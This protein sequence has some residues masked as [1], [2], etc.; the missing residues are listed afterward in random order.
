MANNGFGFNFGFNNDDDDDENKNNSG[1]GNPFGAFSFG[2]NFNVPQ[3]GNL[4]DMLN[5]FGEML[6][7]LGTS[8]NSPEGA[9]PV[10]MD[11]AKR[12]AR[13]AIG[14]VSPVVSEQDEKAV[15]EAVR[16]VDLWL[17]GS[18]DIAT[19]SC[20]VVAWSPVNWLE[21]TLP[22][23]ER[24]YTPI[25]AAMAQ[26]QA[27]QLPEQLRGATEG[28]LPFLRQM[29]SASA[30]VELG[31]TIGEMALNTVSGSE[32][33]FPLAPTATT[34]LLPRAIKE[35]AEAMGVAPQEAMVYIAAR[36]VAHQRLYSHVPWLAERLVASVEEYAAGLDIDNSG[37]EEAMR[38]LNL[39]P[40]D[41]Q[42]IQEK[43]RGFNPEDLGAKFI[44]SNPQAVPRLETLLALVE[45]WVDYV[46]ADALG[47]RIPST[48]ALQEA[49]H[50]RRLEEGGKLFGGLLTITIDVS[51]ILDAR[52]LWRRVSDAVGPAKRDAIW[53]A[54]DFMPSAED[55]ENPAGFI[56]GLLDESGIYDF[57]PISE[58]EALEKLLAEDS[59]EDSTDHTE[60][61]SEDDSKDTSEE[62]DPKQQ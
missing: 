28:I 54:P 34:A 42:S 51:K 16:L 40:S 62:T 9:G 1:S 58:I 35:A 17:S 13:E 50:R 36:E 59:S 19:T 6:A 7:G 5:Q 3:G 39:D 46:V 24:L 41:P 21:A 26:A 32:S 56:D 20:Q 30:G 48:E 49:W 29:G 2:G 61:D 8:M 23:W 22:M 60:D 44:S 4:G 27:A 15:T 47:Q 55:L 37:L 12:F 11:M 57:D 45:G 53:D 14:S 25:A 10:N 43:L 18:T 33:G 52:E 38:N 31:R